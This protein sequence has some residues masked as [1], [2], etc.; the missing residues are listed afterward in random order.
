MVLCDKI[1]NWKGKWTGAHQMFINSLKLISTSS[2]IKNY[3][4]FGK[5][6]IYMKND[7]MKLITTT[8]KKSE[9]FN[10]TLYCIPNGFTIFPSKKT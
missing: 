5:D 4:I 8:T 1:Y 3:K 7:G 6:S 10:K 2:L 9:L